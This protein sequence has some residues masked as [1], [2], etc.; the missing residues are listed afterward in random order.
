[1][2]LVSFS[3][4]KIVLSATL[5][6]SLVAC[7]SGG[8]QLRQAERNFDYLKATQ[9]EPLFIPEGV[10]PP[11]QSKDFVILNAQPKGEPILGSRVDV[12]SPMQVIPLIAGSR[13]ESSDAGL[14]FWFDILLAQSAEETSQTVLNLI[15]DYIGFR[16]SSIARLDEQQRIVESNWLVDREMV[17]SG[18]FFISD[19]AVEQRQK[20]SY[21]LQVKPHGRT[22][23]LTV[24]LVDA[25]LYRNDNDVVVDLDSFD[26]RRLEIIELNR[27]IGYVN[28][29]REEL[30]AQLAEKREQARLAS[31]SAAEKARLNDPSVSL[32]LVNDG[33]TAYYKARANMDKTMKR[34][35]MVLP[36]AGFTITDYIETS[37]SLYLTYKRPDSELL[38]KHGLSGM[39]F[40][41]KDYIFTVGSND[42]ITQITLA[43][44]EGKVLKPREVSKLYPYL[45]ILMKMG[46]DTTNSLSH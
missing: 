31:M 26:R 44:D 17:D 19:K 28:D 21:Q 2:Q 1:M 23:G 11:Q 33:G 20:F 15:R 4:I 24:K 34:L 37:G 25:E 42:N 27:L 18:W 9:I 38:E 10:S 12:R 6:T 32:L 45:A 30:E 41:E 13:T 3:A 5:V 39:Q 14:I 40:E 7:S 43:D 22:V 35:R 16:Q 8:E 36:I 46:L 29:R